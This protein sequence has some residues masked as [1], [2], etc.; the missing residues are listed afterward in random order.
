M[1]ITDVTKIWS[2]ESAGLS[3]ELDF[4]SP[5]DADF[6]EVYDCVG[7]ATDTSLD[8][9]TATGVPALGDQ[10]GSEYLWVTNV[11]VQRIS[12]VYWRVVVS[13]KSFALDPEDPTNNPLLAPAKVKWQTFKTE[14]E[15]DEDFDGN[16]I[17]TT[18]GEPVRGIRRPF[19]DIAAVITQAFSA[20]N[21]FVFYQYIDHVNSDT[22]LGFPPGTGKVDDVS[23]DPQKLEISSTTLEYYN[24]AVKVL[25]RN[26]IR[27][28]PDKAWYIRRVEKGNYVLNA[29]NE[30]VPALV[31]GEQAAAPVY[32]DANGR[33]TDENGAIWSEDK[34]F[35]SIAFSGMGFNF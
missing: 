13:Y 28:T 7:A 25:F 15:I 21:P 2:N 20:F 24:V 35:G 6:V 19:A 33:Q 11:S 14:G 17:V 8:V 16:A 29:S 1:A 26:P 5:G 27:T 3:K 22:F 18:A 34:I 23:A 32:L 9:R 4:E 12:P 10:K 30:L 31:A